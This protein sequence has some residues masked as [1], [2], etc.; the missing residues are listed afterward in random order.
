MDKLLIS[1]FMFLLFSG[2]AEMKP[3]SVPKNILSQD[4][5]ALVLA[6]VLILD[7][8]VIKRKLT[9]SLRNLLNQKYLR[10]FEIHGITKEQFLISHEYYVTRPDQ[11]ELIYQEVIDE[12]SRKEGVLKSK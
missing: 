3:E 6:D 1:I 11:M 9:D 8:G 5:M 4:S 7:E 10:V 12:L 2:C